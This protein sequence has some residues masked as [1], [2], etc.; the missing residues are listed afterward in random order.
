MA[1]ATTLLEEVS[2]KLGPRVL[3]SLTAQGD[4]IIFLDRAELRASFRVLRDDGRLRFNFL[5]DLTAVDY[6]KKKEPRFEVV[7]HLYSLDRGHRLRLRVPVPDDD[8]TVE[9]DRKS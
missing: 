3:D 7:Y 2:R 9:S 4:A 6:W 1:E 8:P 5:S